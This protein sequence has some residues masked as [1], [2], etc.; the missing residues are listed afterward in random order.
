MKC[1]CCNREKELRM[2][3]C[4]DCVEA[5]SVIVDGTNM[6]DEEITTVEGLSK[7]MSKLQY[8]LKKYNITL[9]V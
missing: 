4:F 2:G 1:K 8:I 9:N 3:Y 5:E 6:Y 7:G